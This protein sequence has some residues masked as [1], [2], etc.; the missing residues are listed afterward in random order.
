MFGPDEDDGIA[1]A[2]ARSPEGG[3]WFVLM[4]AALLLSAMAWSGP[5]AG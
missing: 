4:A 2:P 5:L 3:V 1:T